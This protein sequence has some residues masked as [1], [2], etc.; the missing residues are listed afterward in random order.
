MKNTSK[1]T[2]SVMKMSSQAS[3]LFKGLAKKQ[4][5]TK[6]TTPMEKIALI[7]KYRIK[8]FKTSRMAMKHKPR[9][10]SRDIY[11]TIITLYIKTKIKNK[12]KH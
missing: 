8:A 3:L 7:N 10:A 5:T 11:E 4:T 9:C 1:S 12:T 6:W 2:V